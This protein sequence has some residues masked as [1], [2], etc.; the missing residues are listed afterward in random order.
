MGNQC[1]KE[2]DEKPK[3]SVFV[4]IGNQNNDNDEQFLSVN[5]SSN[6]PNIL[7]AGTNA[8]PLAANIGKNHSASS[9]GQSTS[10]KGENYSDNNLQ[11]MDAKLAQQ[12]AAER[13][14]RQRELEKEQNRLEEIVALAGRDMV[15][16]VSRGGGSM[17]SLSSRG[18]SHGLGGYY[19]PGYA[20]LIMHDLQ[21]T[22][23]EY[24]QKLAEQES[25]KTIGSGHHAIS[26]FHKK[27]TSIPETSIID[28]RDAIDVLS[29]DDKSRRRI[30]VEND[31]DLEDMAETFV[32]SV[33]CTK[34]RLLKDIG[35]IVE[36]VLTG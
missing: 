20:S 15:P 32:A 10:T 21:R 4:S 31:L 34:E 19:D 7:A 17:T 23:S 30:E 36:N 25:M 8:T 5:T 12:Q 28:G 9:A 11:S 1:C 18:S 2:A 14:E 33:L 35:P 24:N 6:S 3:K 16:L 22:L 29:S 13:E 26:P 27:Y